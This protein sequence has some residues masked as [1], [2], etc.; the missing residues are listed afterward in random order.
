[1]PISNQLSR[2]SHNLMI[3]DNDELKKVNN[4]WVNCNWW[5]FDIRK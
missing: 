3:N 2:A 1:M 5:L 4:V